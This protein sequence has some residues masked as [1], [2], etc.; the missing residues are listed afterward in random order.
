MLLQMDCIPAG[1]ELFPA[2]DEEQWEFI[3]KII[4]DCDYYLLIIGGKY[5]ST[6]DDGISYTEK[7]YD[8]ATS[9]GIKVAAFIHE[10]LHLLSEEKRES[11]LGSAAKLDSF[12]EKVKKGRIVKFWTKDTDIPGLVASTFHSF[13]KIYPAKGWVRGGSQSPETLLTE[14]NSLRKKNESLKMELGKLEELQSTTVPD[15]ADLDENIL[16]SGTHRVSK[17]VS[18]SIISKDAQ[19]DITLS[20]RK[21]FALISPFIAEMPNEALM[22]EKTEKL[23]FNLTNKDGFS[24]KL[25][26]QDFQTLKLQF[27]ALR[28]ISV[29]YSKTVGGSMAWFWN[30]TANGEALMLSERLIRKNTKPKR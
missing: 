13:I 8:Y 21:I 15:I 10:N 22:R 27:K 19:W 29:R 12:I 6:T 1:M 20:W 11:D 23:L 4:D 18:G 25:D 30:L 17:R 3:K 9:R 7:E 24:P 28:L 5:G 14:I 16:L 26:D 2:A